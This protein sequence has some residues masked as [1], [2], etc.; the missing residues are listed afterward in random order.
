MANNLTSFESPNGNI[1]PNDFANCT[2]DTCP[3]VTS[4]YNYRIDL[5]T[6]AV[7]LGLFSLA[8]PAY[9]GIWFATRRG[10]FFTAVMVIGLV[11]EMI[12]YI[13]RI[14]SYQDQWDETGFLIQIVCLT[15]APAFFS[16]GLYVCLG[17]IVILYGR[18]NSRIP[19]EW[20]TRTV[21]HLFHRSPEE[22]GLTLLVHP[23][24]C[25]IARPPSW[26]C[27][28]GVRCTTKQSKPDAR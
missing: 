4:F 20:Y 21:S 28:H 9:L 27:R 25:L 18:E 8:I 17:R 2:V 5:V 19:A 12:G 7:F 11:A 15:F 1:N 16:A 3:I 23:L 24:R 6:N 14:K 13:G 26:W 22:V 10:H